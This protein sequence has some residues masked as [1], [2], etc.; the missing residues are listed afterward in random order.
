MAS[1]KNHSTDHAIIQ[2][3]DKI[4]ESLVNKEHV[5]G[6]FMD[7]SKAFDTIDHKILIHKLKQYGIRGVT[8]SWF[9]DY[10][11]NRE[12]YVVFQGS[13]SHRCKITCGVPQG[14]ILGP[15]LFLVYVNDIVNASPLLTYVLFADDTNIFCSNKNHH[16]L[17]TT[18]DTELR[19]I[20]AWFKC[21]KLSLNIDKT[22]F[23][24]FTSAHS[25]DIPCNLHIDNLPLVEKKSTKF[26]GLTIDSNLNWN[27][28]IQHIISVISKNIGVLYKLKYFLNEKSLFTLYNALILPH[29]MYCNIVWANCSITKMQQILLLQKKALRICTYSN[30]LANSN[31]IFYHLKT[32]K[33]NDIHT[34]QTATFMFKYTSNLLPSIFRNFYTTNLNVHSYPTR[35]ANDY[36]L[37]NPK[38]I[39]AQKSIRHHG[40]EVWN[41]LPN[42]IKNSKSLY[43]FK[44]L[45][46]KH[47]LTQY[48]T[49]SM[50]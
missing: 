7:L 39:L 30:Y 37:N 26:L 49:I 17:L 5:N 19:N 31:P 38:L 40:S 1:E 23:I 10:L 41:N 4:I 36:H 46:K 8:L 14:S 47:L 32:L 24:H 20:S 48:S 21:N 2:I 43:S 45:V 25:Q 6:I 44:A 3:C 42:H 27:E 50:A 28:H 11:L 12:Q 34:L 13:C 22:N 15:L 16:T 18:L 33:V 35:H 9:E 29:I